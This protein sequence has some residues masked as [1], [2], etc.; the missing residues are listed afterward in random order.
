MDVLSDASSAGRS[1]EG[2]ELDSYPALSLLESPLGPGRE[3]GSSIKSR[4]QQL[5]LNSLNTSGGTASNLS[6]PGARSPPLNLQ[7]YE[8]KMSRKKPGSGS[9]AVTA[10]TPAETVSS[11]HSNANTIQGAASPQ[12]SVLSRE[13]PSMT[14]PVITVISHHTVTSEVK[15]GRN[16]GFLNDFSGS[17]GNVDYHSHGQRS[18]QTQASDNDIYVKTSANI[19]KELPTTNTVSNTNANSISY[20]SNSNTQ[21]SLPTGVATP[22]PTGSTSLWTPSQIQTAFDNC[23]SNASANNRRSITNTANS[24]TQKLHRMASPERGTGSERE[25]PN[26]VNSKNTLKIKDDS[27]SPLSHSQ[28]HSSPSQ[29]HVPHRGQQW[30]FVPPPPGTPQI[31]LPGS[32]MVYSSDGGIDTENLPPSGTT[33]G[34][35]NINVNTGFNQF[36]GRNRQPSPC[37][38]NYGGKNI[39]EAPG[40]KTSMRVSSQGRLTYQD[41]S[42][43]PIRTQG[44]M[45]ASPSPAARGG[46]INQ[47]NL[48]VPRV[49]PHHGTN[50]MTV[51]NNNNNQSDN[52]PG[53]TN[54]IF[55]SNMSQDSHKSSIVSQA[56]HSHTGTNRN[57]SMNQAWLSVPAPKSLS[58]MAGGTNSNKTQSQNSNT[59]TASASS[60]RSHHSTGSEIYINNFKTSLTLSYDKFKNMNYNMSSGHKSTYGNVPKEDFSFNNLISREGTTTVVDNRNNST[61]SNEGGGPKFPRSGSLISADSDSNTGGTTNLLNVDPRA[62]RANTNV[63][64]G[65]LSG[66]SRHATTL[67]NTSDGPESL[68]VVVQNDL[69]LLLDAHQKKLELNKAL[70]NSSAGRTFQLALDIRDALDAYMASPVQFEGRDPLKAHLNMNFSWGRKRRNFLGHLGV[71]GVRS[72][73]RKTEDNLYPNSAGESNANKFSSTNLGSDGNV[74]T[75]SRWSF[76]HPKNHNHNNTRGSKKGVTAGVT[77]PKTTT[78]RSSAASREQ[79]IEDLRGSTSSENLRMSGYMPLPNSFNNIASNVK[80]VS[81]G[82]TYVV[83][84]DRNSSRGSSF[85]N[86]RDS[87]G[88]MTNGYNSTTDTGSTQTVNLISNMVFK[89]SKHLGLA[90]NLRLK[91]RRSAAFKGLSWFSRFNDNLKAKRPG[92]LSLTQQKRLKVVTAHRYSKARHL[93]AA[94]RSIR[95]KSIAETEKYLQENASTV[96]DVV[97]RGIEQLH[98]DWEHEKEPEIDDFCSEM[99]KLNSREPE[100]PVLRDSQAYEALLLPAFRKMNQFQNTQKFGRTRSELA[101]AAI[102]EGGEPV[103]ADDT[104][105]NLAPVELPKRKKKKNT[106]ARKKKKKKSSTKTNSE[107]LNSAEEEG[108]QQEEFTA[109]SASASGSS[110]EDSEE[111]VA[112]ASMANNAPDSDYQGDDRPTR[113]SGSGS[114]TSSASLSANNKSSSDE[115]RRTGDGDMIIDGINYP[116]QQQQQHVADYND[117]IEMYP[118][119]AALM[120]PKVSSS[121]NSHLSGSRHASDP[122]DSDINTD[123]YITDTEGGTGTG[124]GTAITHNQTLSNKLSTNNDGL[125]SNCNTSNTSKSSLDDLEESDVGLHRRDKNSDFSDFSGDYYGEEEEEESSDIDSL[126]DI[127]FSDAS[128]D[129]DADLGPNESETTWG[130][131]LLNGRGVLGDN[132][133]HISLLLN[134]PFHDLLVHYIVPRL[135]GKTSLQSIRTRCPVY[136][137]ALALKK[138]SKMQ[139]EWKKWRDLVV[140][141]YLVDPTS[142]RFRDLASGWLHHQKAVRDSEE[143]IAREQMALEMQ[144]TFEIQDRELAPMSEG[145]GESGVG[146]SHSSLTGSKDE[147]VLAADDSN[148]Q[149]EGPIPQVAVSAVP[150][151][152]RGTPVLVTSNVN[153]VPDSNLLAVAGRKHSQMSGSQ[154]APST[155]PPDASNSNLSLTNTSF[156]SKNISSQGSRSF[157]GGGTATGSATNNKGTTSP[158]PDGTNTNPTPATNIT[159][160]MPIKKILAQHGSLESLGLLDDDNESDG[161]IVEDYARKESTGFLNFNK[162]FIRGMSGGSIGESSPS[163]MRNTGQ[164]IMARGNKLLEKVSNESSTPHSS[165]NHK[166]ILTVTEPI[167]PLPYSSFKFSQPEL[168]LAFLAGGEHEEVSALDTA[169]TNPI[170][171]G[172]IAL[173]IA[174]VNKN[175]DQ[176]RLLVE[177]SANVNDGDL[178]I[179]EGFGKFFSNRLYYGGSALNFSAIHDQLTPEGIC[180]FYPGLAAQAG[181]NFGFGDNRIAEVERRDCVQ[182]THR[183]LENNAIESELSGMGKLH[184]EAKTQGQSATVT[185]LQAQQTARGGKDGDHGTTQNSPTDHGNGNNS[186]PNSKTKLLNTQTST[187]DFRSQKYNSSSKKNQG[188]A[189]NNGNNI[190]NNNSSKTSNVTVTPTSNCTT[191]NAAA[192]GLRFKDDTDSVTHSSNS[193]T[194]QQIAGMGAQIRASQGISGGIALSGAPSQPLAYN[195]SINLKL[196]PSSITN[197]QTSRSKSNHSPMVSNATDGN[198]SVTALAVA[199]NKSLDGRKTGVPSLLGSNIVHFLGETASTLRDSLGFGGGGNTSPSGALTS[200]IVNLDREKGVRPARAQEAANAAK[201]VVAHAFTDHSTGTLHQAVYREKGGI[202]K[203]TQA[204]KVSL[205][206]VPNPPST[207]VFLYLLWHSTHGFIGGDT[208]LHLKDNLNEPESAT[209]TGNIEKSQSPEDSTNANNNINDKDLNINTN[210]QKLVGTV[211]ATNNLQKTKSDSDTT[212][213]S[214]LVAGGNVPSVGLTATTSVTPTTRSSLTNTI[215]PMVGQLSKQLAEVKEAQLLLQCVA[216]RGPASKNLHSETTSDPMAPST[217]TNTLQS[218]TAGALGG[219]LLSLP[220]PTSP[221]VSVANTKI[222]TFSSYPSFD[223]VYA[224]A[225]PLPNQNSVSKE[226]GTTSK[227][228]VLNQSHNVTSHRLSK[229][230]SRLSKDLSV[231]TTVTPINSNTE[232]VVG[233]GIPI[234][235]DEGAQT[236]LAMLKKSHLTPQT[237]QNALQLLSCFQH[238]PLEQQAVQLNCLKACLLQQQH[239]LMMQAQI[240]TE[241]STLPPTNR[242]ASSV[243]MENNFVNRKTRRLW[244]KEHLF[245]NVKRQIANGRPPPDARR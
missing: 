137:D 36:G 161:E 8:R 6:L 156:G 118:N 91:L 150:N 203:L 61:I 143:A 114:G 115:E 232:S 221:S 74:R 159:S 25:S 38:A 67:A 17:E 228:D 184:A 113:I 90:R 24:E 39:L 197:S 79:I 55:A 196:A 212:S 62:T 164:C 241:L 168:N 72:S 172:E 106:K 12:Y 157:G 111:S 3:L 20:N 46:P 49:Y 77:T 207:G 226:D 214:N 213:S 230:V 245:A 41:G 244:P 237:T 242:A 219:P 178:S 163:L 112:R 174:I 103:Q 40:T 180:R 123:S 80:K 71:T 220:Q 57:G 148:L 183:Q 32:S 45:S 215:E 154:Y 27:Y 42:E 28:T 195:T 69:Q 133:L 124:A 35:S 173:H 84:P 128:S 26:S 234:G 53:N 191:P 211:S 92:F 239:L 4:M 240:E 97:S 153:L 21:P 98:W 144:S 120:S 54:N 86:Y 201:A 138:A 202:N 132:V 231:N 199:H 101:L 160:D 7:A 109:Q 175:L 108:S 193:I 1:P 192:R 59:N 9:P 155:I 130:H 85:A 29:D 104:M 44:G 140:H 236:S 107:K 13:A 2:G 126:D 146:N 225:K 188:F 176:V 117:D 145:E 18:G 190:N 34:G 198:T 82:R 141:G 229:D 19:F 149:I 179:M 177:N 56:S 200:N 78:T 48:H 5:S 94:K 194:Q 235:T 52:S 186:I 51:G 152:S 151:S 165:L 93:T 75:G 127:G 204:A 50:N 23:S 105:E 227:Q 182:L 65:T 243:N 147:I 81:F 116:Q 136:V 135:R 76:Q 15:S 37:F 10:G 11:H 60:V 170:Y 99:M 96:T 167:K 14:V 66:K 83:T 216:Q 110:S 142:K 121:I 63:K 209:V 162:N 95:E 88:L 30:L 171:R 223:P 217:S 129:T 125:N 47:Q 70:L 187:L 169:Y 100:N 205:E 31:P 222:S 206:A 33:A 218:P 89:L 68:P 233:V 208:P 210:S 238:L 139:Y 158:G 64:G 181:G 122:D 43:S 134:S 166:S 16:S 119:S 185:N 131:I 58:H 22:K 87:G 224:P 73:K 189:V 102:T